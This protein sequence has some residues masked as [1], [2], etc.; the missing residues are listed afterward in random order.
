MTVRSLAISTSVRLIDPSLDERAAEI[1]SRCPGLGSIS[2]A[3]NAL[4]A[5]RDEEGTMVLGAI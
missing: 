3:A 4:S 1:L 2:A 5:A